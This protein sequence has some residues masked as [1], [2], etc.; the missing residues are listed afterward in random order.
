M[1]LYIRLSIEAHG[2]SSRPVA[3]FESARLER[4]MVG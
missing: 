3:Y 4:S 2:G 1:I